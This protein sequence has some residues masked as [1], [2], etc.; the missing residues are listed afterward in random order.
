M[1]KNRMKD[2]EQKGKPRRLSLH[3]ET[4]QVLNDPA[5]LELAR[6]GLMMSN[7]ESCGPATSASTSDPC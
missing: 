4:I 5:L 1:K 7:F 6:G 3:R 2:Q